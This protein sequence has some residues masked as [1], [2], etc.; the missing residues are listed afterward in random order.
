VP[1]INTAGGEEIKEEDAIS[2]EISLK[3]VRFH[4]PTKKDVQ[5]LKGVTID[6]QKNKVIALV[7]P[8][9]KLF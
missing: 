5:V 2:G 7:G 4:Y 1:K 3:D 8:S 9:G 6:I